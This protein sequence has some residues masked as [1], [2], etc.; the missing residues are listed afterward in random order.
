MPTTS[1]EQYLLEM[2]NEARLNPMGNAMRYLTSFSPLSSDDKYIQSALTAYNVDGAALLKAFTS[3]T[4]VAPVAWND[5]LAK[6]ATDHSTAMIEADTQAHQ[7]TGETDLSGRVKAAGYANFKQ[8]GE[9][10]YAYGQNLPYTHAAFMID[11]GDGPAGM[12][13]PAGHRLNIMSPNFTEVGIDATSENNRATSVGPFVVT[14]DFGDRG[15][16]YVTGVAYND[17]LRDGFYTMG[18]GVSGLVVSVGRT[19]VTSGVSGGYNLQINAGPVTLNLSGAGLT[20]TITVQTVIVDENL[21][22]DVVNGSTLL[23]SGDITVSGAVTIVKV[24]SAAGAAVKSG[25]GSQDLRGLSG[26]DVLDSGD[27][28]DWLRGNEGDDRLLGGAGRDNLEGGAGNDEIEGG[29]DID[30]AHF[31]GI[32]ADYLFAQ[33][34]DGGLSVTGIKTGSDILHGVEFLKFSDGQYSIA[35]LGLITNRAPTVASS[36][37]I[38]TRASSAKQVTVSAIDLDGDRIIFTASTAAHGTVTGGAGGAFVYT[39]NADYVGT[40]TFRVSVSDG[41]GGTSAQTVNVRILEVNDAPFV[42]S[43][44]TVSAS[45]DTLKQVTVVASDPDGDALT[46]TASSAAHGS[47]TGGLNGIFTYMPA[48]G[49]S[50]A[51]KFTVSVDDGHGHVTKQTVNMQVTFVAPAASIGIGNSFRLFMSDGLVDHVGGTGTIIGTNGFQDITLVNQPGELVFD[52]SFARGGDVIRIPGNASLYSASLD[53]SRVRLADGDTTLLIPIGLEGTSLVFADG[54]R[55]LRYDSQTATVKLGGQQLNTTSSPVTAPSDSSPVPQGGGSAATG[56]VFLSEGGL[57]SIGGDHQ[58]FGTTSQEK[59]YYSG[60]DLVLDATF[61]RGGDTM[62]M[63]L[64][65]SAYH[66]YI[67]GSTLVLMSSDGNVIIPVGTVGLK[68]VFAGEELLLRFDA[69]SQHIMIGDVTITSLNQL[70]PN[71]LISLTGGGDEISIDRGSPVNTVSIDLEEAKDFILV[72][73]GHVETNVIVHGFDQGDYI[74]VLDADPANY[75]FSTGSGANGANDLIIVSRLGETSNEI[76]LVDVIEHPGFVFDLQSAQAAIGDPFMLFGAELPPEAGS[77][78][79]NPDVI[80]DESTDHGSSSQVVTMQ[81]SAGLDYTL[82]ED[83]QVES[84]VV[85]LG[86]DHGDLLHVVNAD[87]TNYSFG[88]RNGPGGEDDLRITA[89][90]GD[91]SNEIVLVD[92]IQNPG[93]VYDLATAEAAVGVQFI[94]FG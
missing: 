5:A 44:Q 50:G 6:A 48:K 94:T 8:L 53:G 52:T 24:I 54:V 83:G 36:Q 13:S 60:G 87:P 19:S 17:D 68:L 45:Q 82:Q 28:D 69:A 34:S 15:L 61:N 22:L 73:N 27:G 63:P 31:S 58:V 38:D 32:R 30:I 77:G 21:K 80:A 57:I 42:A 35:D 23:T 56:R 20:G 40:D 2:I 7:V 74:R 81:L 65:K 91:T 41:R 16:L 33:T 59:I 4:P 26:A 37:S 85:I 76:V 43:A 10:I 18:E 14:E 62:Y 51:D 90:L 39:P 93:F 67:S 64:P 92:V 89:R 75:S 3:L 49:Y 88:T 72:D 11:W 71:S 29:A 12:Q 9:N 66:A 25:A 55:A 78:Q 79:A 46:Y 84:N 1:M 70:N 47:V 86:F